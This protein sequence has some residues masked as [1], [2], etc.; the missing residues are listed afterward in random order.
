MVESEALSGICRRLALLSGCWGPARMMMPLPLQI[1]FCKTAQCPS[2]QILLRYRRHHL[3]ITDRAAVE[4]HL[5]ACDFCSAELQ[6]L[7][8]H[9]SEG[10]HYRLAEMPVRLRSLA[11]DFL[12]RNAGAVLSPDGSDRHRLSH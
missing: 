7:M 2:S 4:I 8:Q 12:L 3:P 10:E 5:R 6:L 11:E 1:N 9:R